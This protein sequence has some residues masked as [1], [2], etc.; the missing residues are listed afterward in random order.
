M[1]PND[2][3]VRLTNFLRGYLSGQKIYMEY[4]KTKFGTPLYNDAAST[5]NRNFSMNT[6][7]R[8]RQI[9]N[10]K[11]VG[12]KNF[13]FLLGILYL[14][15]KVVNTFFSNTDFWQSSSI[16]TLCSCSFISI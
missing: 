7:Q 11:T 9:D 10:E 5:E 8:I 3:A 12:L 1:K 4:G 2:L 15:T 6:K 14:N 13:G 16:K